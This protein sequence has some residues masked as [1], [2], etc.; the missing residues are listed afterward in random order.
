MNQGLPLILLLLLPGGVVEQESGSNP[1]QTVELS[2]LEL[3]S[4][5]Q[6]TANRARESCVGLETAAGARGSGVVISK[7]G[8]ILTVA[9]LFDE[10]SRDAVK[11]R[12]ADGA[13]RTARLTHLDKGEDLALLCF[14]RFL[15]PAEWV[16]TVVEEDSRIEP[17]SPMVAVGHASGRWSK[18]S[19]PSVRLGFG[20]V[21]ESTGTIMSTCRV[22]V[23]D[24]GGG[25]FDLDGRLQGLHR[26]V[27]AA[28]KFSSHLPV[29]RVAQVWPE[30]TTGVTQ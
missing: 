11:V 13:I 6:E 18:H 22:T 1:A 27:D 17:G 16:A 15:P 14:E 5:I 12:C 2:V 29:S 9:H 24:S 20:F 21:R 7:E 19:M 8:L 25:L 26:T 10:M 4:R 28:G 30:L 23:G 3:E